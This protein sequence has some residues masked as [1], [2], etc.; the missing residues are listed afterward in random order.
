MKFFTALLAAAIAESTE[1]RWASVGSSAVCSSGVG[2]YDGSPSGM[3]YMFQGTDLLG[4]LMDTTISSGW[5]SLQPLTQYELKVFAGDAGPCES[6]TS[7]SVGSPFVSNA[8]GIGYTQ[9][10]DPNCDLSGDNSI[11]GAY[12]QLSTGGTEVSCCQISDQMN[13]GWRMLDDLEDIEEMI[14][15]QN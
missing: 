4:N 2:S 8:V 12:M 9:M 7:Q 1:A 10:Q 14:D 3:N 15:E 13:M 5:Y 11:I 6:S